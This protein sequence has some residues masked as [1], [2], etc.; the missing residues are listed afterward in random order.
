VHRVD[1]PCRSVPSVLVELGDQRPYGDAPAGDQSG[2]RLPGL[3]ANADLDLVPPGGVTLGDKGLCRGRPARDRFEGVPPYGGGFGYG[4][5]RGR[6]PS[7]RGFGASGAAS[8]QWGE[9]ARKA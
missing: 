3:G 9:Q 5:G 8:E 4:W 2:I 6:W 7:R 1:R